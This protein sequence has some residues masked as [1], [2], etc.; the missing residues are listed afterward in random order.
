[1]SAGEARKL[2]RPLR[3]AVRRGQRAHDRDARRDQAR[4]RC[5]P[6]SIPGV[7]A[8]A[9]VSTQ[10]VRR[11]GWVEGGAGG[12]RRRGGAGRIAVVAR[13]AAGGGAE[14]FGARLGL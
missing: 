5:L 6:A 8:L 10:E 12:G 3:G 7:E 14:A 11:G 9:G 1:M 4:G 2:E 13:I